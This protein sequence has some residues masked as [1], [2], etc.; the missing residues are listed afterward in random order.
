[1]YIQSLLRSYHLKG[2][3]L[4]GGEL[5]IYSEDDFLLKLSQVSGFSVHS[6]KHTDANNIKA[7]VEFK[8]MNTLT[9]MAWGHGNGLRQERNREATI[10][11]GSFRL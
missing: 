4:T 8:D 11:W 2:S 7:L 1:M 3:Y 9:L 10:I 5:N 6:S